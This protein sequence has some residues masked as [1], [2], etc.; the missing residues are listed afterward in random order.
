MVNVL[1]VKINGKHKLYCEYNKGAA[2]VVSSTIKVIKREIPDAQFTSLIQLPEEFAKEHGVRV[3]SNKLLA[4]REHSLGTMTKSTLNFIRCALWVPLHKLFPNIAKSLINS[5][6]LKEYSKADVIIDISMDLLSTQV[7]S[8]IPII[9]HCKELL[10]AAMLKKPIVIWAQSPGPFKSKLTSWLIRFTLSKTALIILREEVSLEYIEKLRVRGPHIYVTADPA[11][12]LE[13]AP[14]ERIDEIFSKEGISVR[15]GPIIGMTIGWSNVA[16]EIAFKWYQRYIREV[17]KIGNIL[18][19]EGFFKLL[20]K[21]VT[22]LPGIKSS[23]NLALV[24]AAK[25]IDYLVDKTGAIIVLIPHDYNP[26]GDDRVLLGD[27]SEKAK[28]KDKVKL[29]AGDYSAPEIKAIIGR[30]DFFVGGKMHASIAATSMIIPTIAIQYGHKFYGIMR[31]LGQ[32]KYVCNTLTLEE[33][34]LKFVEAWTEKERI[35]GELKN[36]IEIV[37]K[38]AQYSAELVKDLLQS[39]SISSASL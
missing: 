26:D 25:I 10:I 3:I 29:L 24:E 19:P 32:E 17:Y 11:F 6:E 33:V 27:I 15:N 30:C 21:R 8:A 7:V 20:K 36:N 2:G 9:E 16:S 37:K 18:L 12:L 4:N 23:S 13:P 1:L 35:K 38:K 22:K 34:K 39:R 14:D 28:R 5:N 31:L